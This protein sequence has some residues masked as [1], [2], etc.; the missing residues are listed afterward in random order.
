MVDLGSSYVVKLK[1][2]EGTAS[3]ISMDI[4]DVMKLATVMSTTSN[5]N[6]ST[7][8]AMFYK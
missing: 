5:V 8:Q 7:S 4:A 1:E 6:A 3:A 2:K